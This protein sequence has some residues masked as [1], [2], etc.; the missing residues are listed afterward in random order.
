MIK[1]VDF[2]CGAGG[3]TR[4]LKNAEID[5]VVGVDLNED[6]RDTY[7][8]NNPPVRFLCRDIR[9]LSVVELEDELGDRSGSTLLFAACAPCQPFSKQRTE[10]KD[11]GQRTLLGETLRFVEHFRPEYLLF[12]NVPGITRVS[13]NSTFRRVVSTI[14][15]MG[16]S[17]DAKVVDAKSYGVPQTRRRYVL[18]GS[19]SGSVG[20]PKATHGPGLS[21]YVTVRQ[22]IA[23][24]PPIG[25]GESDPSVPNH[26]ASLLHEVNLRRIS[27]TPHNG[28]DRRGWPRGLTLDCH[29]NDYNGHTD[30]Y[31]RMW[32]DRPAPALTCKC[33]SLSNGRY[34]HPEQN[35]AISLRE[36]AALQSFPDGYIFYST[37]KA[38]VGD[39]IG[40]AVPVHLAEA[41]GRGVVRAFKEHRATRIPG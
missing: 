35:R 40:N 6:Y 16:Y 32:W 27:A 39:Q 29:S 26:R 2:F 24:Y 9:A 7:E 1:A 34:G 18:V 8:K 36:A 12:E 41:L 38:S 31:G 25:A 17:C 33:H 15:R 13:G 30:V 28:G 21:P 14:S 10:P 5:V 4:G 20:L 19:R 3:L 22:A 11:L 23:Q 37:S